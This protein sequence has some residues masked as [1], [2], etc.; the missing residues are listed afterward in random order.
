MNAFR[1]ECLPIEQQSWDVLEPYL[2][3][4]SFEGRFV[5]TAKGPLA[6]ELQK[7][8]GDVLVNASREDFTCIEVKAELKHTG[9]LFLERWSNRKFFTPGWFETLKTDLLWCHFL[10]VDT[11][12][13]LRFAK[14]RQWMYWHDGRGHPLAH[15]FEIAKQGKYE[16]LNDTWGY[17]VSVEHLRTAKLIRQEFHPARDAMQRDA[18]RE[19]D[20]YDSGIRI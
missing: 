9:N 10:D 13:E 18:W 11:V 12:Y 20:A 8:V 3:Q 4:R 14:L 15:R 16:Q 2:K 1:N 17:I 6:L 7:S 19:L 5:R